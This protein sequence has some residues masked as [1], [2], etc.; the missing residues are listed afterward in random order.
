MRRRDLDDA[1]MQVITAD[2]G[3]PRVSLLPIVGRTVVAT[4]V[5]VSGLVLAYVVFATPFLAQALPAGR[6]DAAQ[7]VAGM[8]LW[9]VA[10]VAPAGFV[11][12]GVNR[13]ARDLASVRDGSTRRSTALRALSQLPSDI[14]VASGLQLPDGRG[15][16]ELVVGAFGAAILRELPPAAVT[17]L[18]DGQWE[19]RTTKR[20]VP[21]ENPLER[22]TR[23]AERVRR[24]LGHDDADF[25]VKVY[26]AVVGPAPTVARTA[27][28]AVLTPDQ[29]GAWIAA[30]PA[31]RS[32]T[33][34][35]REQILE[36]VREAA[37]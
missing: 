30:L 3:T 33:A 20:W 13:L 19:L 1:P 17:R 15:V 10:L 27:G 23:D 26:A 22:A 29:L 18:R 7:T 6:P 37:G 35:R 11:L 36:L 25:V 31:Q 8:A 12:V 21:L 28:C 5:V 14:V 32:L 2:R 9:A 24:W 16:S 4:L 34:G